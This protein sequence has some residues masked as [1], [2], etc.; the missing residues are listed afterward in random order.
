MVLENASTCIGDFMYLSIFL[1]V[2]LDSDFIQVIGRFF[3][4]WNDILS[5]FIHMWGENRHLFTFTLFLI[6]YLA[7]LAFRFSLSRDFSYAVLYKYTL[8]VQTEHR[9]TS[10]N[11]LYSCIVQEKEFYNL[12]THKRSL[13]IICP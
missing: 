13:E 7:V 2:V 1:W 12:W 5:C 6:Y 3:V 4:Q 10:F 11:Y 8:R 9:V